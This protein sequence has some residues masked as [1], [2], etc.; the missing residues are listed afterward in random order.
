MFVLDLR[1]LILAFAVFNFVHVR[2]LAGNSC[3][4]GVVNPWFCSWSYTHEPTTLLVAALFGRAN[5]WWGNIVS[6]VL[7]GYLIAYFLH[8]LI[9]LYDPWEGL[10]NDWKVNRSDYPYIVGSWDSQYMLAL[11]IFCVSAFFFTRG[12]LRWH[13]SRRAADN[14]SLDRSQGK[15]LLH[16]SHQA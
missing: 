9:G 16:L 5:R 10:R 15:R 8:L 7:S 12:I 14:K 11:V 1:S 2:L 4:C 3:C 13:A 6:L